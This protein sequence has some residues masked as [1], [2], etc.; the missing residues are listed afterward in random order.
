MKQFWIV[1]LLLL[2]AVPAFAQV[3]AVKNP[4]SVSFT[5]PDHATLT[6]YEIDVINT[7]GVVVGTILSGKGTQDAAG[8]VTL[9]YSIQNLATGTYTMRIRSVAGT[10]K[11]DDSLPSDPFVRAPG[12]PSK[13]TVK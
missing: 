8:I 11:S 9:T 3:P 5:S 7:S 13:P 12:A 2:V 10:A 1:A 4:T 6:G